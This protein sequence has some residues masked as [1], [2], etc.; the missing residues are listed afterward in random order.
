MDAQNEQSPASAIAAPSFADLLSRGFLTTG[1]T[2]AL[3]AY[4]NLSVP[5]LVVVGLVS[6]TYLTCHAW[7]TVAKI[8]AGVP[9]KA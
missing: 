6:V 7:V 4:G 8:R 3:A 5:A 2:T 1:V 9:V